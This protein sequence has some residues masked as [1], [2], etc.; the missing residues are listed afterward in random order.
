MVKRTALTELTSGRVRIY[1][2]WTGRWLVWLVPWT[3][4]CKYCAEVCTVKF[5][6]L[7]QQIVVGSHVTLAISGVVQCEVRIHRRNNLVIVHRILS[8]GQAELD[9]LLG[10]DSL[11]KFARLPT[12]PLAQPSFETIAF[13]SAVGAAV[14]LAEPSEKLAVADEACPQ[15]LLV[16]CFQGLVPCFSVVPVPPTIPIC[17][18]KIQLHRHRNNQTSTGLSLPSSSTGLCRIV[19]AKA[20]PVRQRLQGLSASQV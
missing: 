19:R 18:Y 11:T 14:F 5:R 1:G 9:Q 20:T 6:N 17:W 7:P 8:L 15:Y 16:S 3:H 10:Y 13:H 2:D 4:V 12:L